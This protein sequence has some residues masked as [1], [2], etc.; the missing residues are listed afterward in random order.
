VHLQLSAVWLDQLSER[1][2][3]AGLRFG[4]QLAVASPTA[5]PFSRVWSRF[6]LG[7]DTGRG[8]NSA[9]GGRPVSR[10]CGA[11]IIDGSGV[12]GRRNCQQLKAI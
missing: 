8:R 12:G 4:D 1:V 5:A 9:L 7:V 2:A 6:H 3:V 10:R 11:Y